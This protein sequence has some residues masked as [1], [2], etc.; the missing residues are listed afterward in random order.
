[1][2]AK[3]RPKALSKKKDMFIRASPS[4]AK[5]IK[6]LSILIFD[7]WQENCKDAGIN[8]PSIKLAVDYLL[9]AASHIADFK[10]NALTEK[11]NLY[12][13]VATGNPGDN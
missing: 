4:A 8:R 9:V 5:Q 13:K 3:K 12:L 1:M 2:Q 7:R 6:T 11:N 10:I